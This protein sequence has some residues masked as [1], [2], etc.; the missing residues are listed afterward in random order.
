MPRLDEP[1]W[2]F[3]V[4]TATRGEPG[5]DPDHVWVYD[6]ELGMR[7]PRPVRGTPVEAGGETFPSQWHLDAYITNLHRE[8]EG[9][10]HRLA[11]LDDATA[12]WQ[13]TPNSDHRERLR[14]DLE[15]EKTAALAELKRLEPAKSTKA[16]G[17]G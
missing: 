3:S 12:W 2:N 1:G 17:T 4:G 7:V 15:S 10:N 14:S 6:Q 13:E 8:I 11:H 16:R 9:V 5:G